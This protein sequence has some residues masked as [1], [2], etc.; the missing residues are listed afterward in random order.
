MPRKIVLY[1]A[2][3]L[4]GFI[5]RENGAIDWL[6]GE[7]GD[8]NLDFGFER[9]NQT[10]DTI[11]MGRTTYEQ[12]VNELSPQVWPYEGKRVI[13]FTH[14][15]NYP[16]D[17][18]TTFNGELAPWLETLRAEEGSNIWLAGGGRQIEEFLF[19]DLIDEYIISV[20]PVLLGKG[21]RLFNGGFE[22]LDLRLT[23]MNQLDGLVELTYV[24]RV[25]A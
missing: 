24:R 17:R 20:A 16:D 11:L 13:V 14:Q 7:S 9:F 23:N 21:I 19:C 2:M 10:I 1:I 18:V 12:V 6:S 15:Q 4:D 22:Q 5:A 3:S 25:A 8:P